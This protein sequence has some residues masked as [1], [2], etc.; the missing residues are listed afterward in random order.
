MLLTAPLS[1]GGEADILAAD[2]P[3]ATI[4]YVPEW[5]LAIGAG[6]TAE[7]WGLNAIG[8]YT[9]DMYASARNIEVSMVVKGRL[10]R[11]YF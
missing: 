7:N 9:S 8:S 4:P 5:K 11:I 2:E 1:E 10:M 3:G 6:L